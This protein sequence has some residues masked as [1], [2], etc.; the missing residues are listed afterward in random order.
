MTNAERQALVEIRHR[1]SQAVNHPTDPI[2]HTTVLLAIGELAA[3]LDIPEDASRMPPSFCPVCHAVETWTG[4]LETYPAY[5]VLLCG[6]GH[7]REYQMTIEEND[8]LSAWQHAQ[9]AQVKGDDE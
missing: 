4:T 3:L 9:Y 6:N 8:A 1:L 2:W 5:L 7:R